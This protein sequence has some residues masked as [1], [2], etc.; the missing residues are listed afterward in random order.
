M[1]T[2]LVNQALADAEADV[3][4][5]RQQMAL[6][7]QRKELLAKN[8]ESS[9]KQAFDAQDR[10]HDGIIQFSEGLTPE[11]A[12]LTRASPNAKDNRATVDPTNNLVFDT[13][14]QEV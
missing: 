1:T 11:T 5:K 4:Q 6:L 7:K 9:T 3:R 12:G 10:N 14:D 8:L 13:L 2:L